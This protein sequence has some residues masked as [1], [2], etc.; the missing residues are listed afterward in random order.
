MIHKKNKCFQVNVFRILNIKGKMRQWS[1][2]GTVVELMT[3]YW[4]GI[5]KQSMGARNQG[6][7]I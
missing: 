7:V 6:F 1:K 4:A 3:V 2:F 5:F